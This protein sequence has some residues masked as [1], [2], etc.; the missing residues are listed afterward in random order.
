MQQQ[1]SLDIDLNLLKSSFKQTKLIDSKSKG[2]ESEKDSD[3]DP[4][5]VIED[6]DELTD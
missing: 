1:R 5:K 3:F 2:K 6:K 4:G